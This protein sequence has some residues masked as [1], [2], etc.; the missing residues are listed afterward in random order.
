MIT[1]Y[2]G[3][4]GSGKSY[5]AMQ[6]IRRALLRKKNVI[7]NLSIDEKKI[8]RNGKR[9]IGMFRY[10]DFFEFDVS[11][12]YIHSLA[13][14]TKGKE[15]QTLLVVDECQIAFNARDWQKKER[16]EWI[17]FFTRH[18]HLGYNIILITQFDRFVDRQIRGLFEYEFKHRKV[19]NF[20]PFCL[21]PFTLFIIIEYWYGS[22]VRV[23]KSFMVYK[24]WLARLYDSYSMFDEFK[25][26]YAN[27]SAFEDVPQGLPMRGSGGEGVPPL[28]SS[29]NLKPYHQ[30]ADGL[31]VCAKR[32][33][34]ILYAKLP[35]LPAVLKLF[36]QKYSS[37]KSKVPETRVDSVEDM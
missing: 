1:L 16:R 4:P 24:P 18:R 5:H 13:H 31:A 23:S 12:L 36:E 21:L 17:I 15:G 19:N 9:K 25:D 30:Q 35:G 29:V 8:S 26:E 20:G 6:D 7:T 27:P 28:P 3:T 34:G 11:E 37:Y 10:I 32:K 22:R 2:S 33:L 14:H